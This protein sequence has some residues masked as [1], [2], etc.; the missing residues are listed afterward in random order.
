MHDIHESTEGFRRLVVFIY[1]AI[2]RQISSVG[3]DYGTGRP[4]LRAKEQLLCCLINIQA[5]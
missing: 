2:L 3:F 4:K 5:E 1:D